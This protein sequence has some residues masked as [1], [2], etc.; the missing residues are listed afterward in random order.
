VRDTGFLRELAEEKAAEIGRL[1]AEAAR[2]LGCAA[3]LEAAEA[4]IRAGMLR[5]GAAVLGELLSADPGYR[6][7]ARPAG[8]ATGLPSLATGRR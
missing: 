3:G 4:V 1:A 2:S 5:L 7:H 6:G 8:A